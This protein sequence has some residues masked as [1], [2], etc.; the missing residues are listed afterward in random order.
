MKQAFII[1]NGPSL[2]KIDI[3]LLKGKDT[4]SFNRAYIAYEEWGFY[5][6]Y[7]MCIDLRVLYNIAADINKLIKD[8]PIERFFLR[9]QSKDYIIHNEKVTFINTED[10]PKRFND[11]SFDNLVYWGDVSVCSLQVLYILG[12][13]EAVLLGCDAKYKEYPSGIK[14]L[15]RKYISTE[16]NDPNHFRPDYFG[17]GTEYS[18]P[19]GRGHYKSW[20]RI[21]KLINGKMKIY[22]SSPGSRLN[23]LF[24]YKELCIFTDTY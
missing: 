22:S 11:L 21:A 18:K 7:F 4:I 15:G 24:E 3:S 17:K 6:K 12:Y 20:K 1:G 13:Q 16:N 10:I 14:K 9:D 5:P 23:K 19:S 2:N 8:S